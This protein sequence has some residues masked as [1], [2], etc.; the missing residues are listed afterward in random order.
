[1][2]G[3][4]N[5]VNPNSELLNDFINKISRSKKGKKR[6]MI[7]FE[8]VARTENGDYLVDSEEKQN[9]RF[10]LSDFSSVSLDSGIGY[11]A[12]KALRQ[13]LG[14]EVIPTS[15]E[16]V[17][18]LSLPQEVETIGS[19]VV[20]ARESIALQIAHRQQERDGTWDTDPV[21]INDSLLVESDNNPKDADAY[22]SVEF[23]VNPIITSTNESDAGIAGDNNNDNTSAFKMVELTNT[24]KETFDDGG[25]AVI[26]TGPDPSF[27]LQ[28]LKSNIQVDSNKVLSTETD[29]TSPE[30]FCSPC[31]PVDGKLYARPLRGWGADEMG[32]DFQWED[33]RVCCFCHD[34][35]EDNIVGRFMAFNDG[36]YGHLNCI[37]WSTDVVERNGVLTNSFIARE[38]VGKSLCYLCRQNGAT[39]GCINKKKCKRN[40]HLRCALA[41]KVL[42]FEARRTSDAISSCHDIFTLSFCPEHVSESISETDLKLLWTPTRDIRRCI[43][44]SD[45]DAEISTKASDILSQKRSDKAIRMGSITILSI[46]NP[47]IDLTDFHTPYHIYP[48]R[49]RSARIF[50]SMKNPLQRTVYFF[51]IFKF[52]DFEGMDEKRVSYIKESIEVNNLKIPSPHQSSP[53]NDPSITNV[54]TDGGPKDVPVFRIVAVDSPEEP[55]FTLS[56]ELAYTI[57]ADKVQQ[58]NSELRSHQKHCL[59]KSMKSYGLNGHQFFGIGLP[60]VRRAIEFIPESVSTMIGLD[61]VMH[62]Q[63]KP[64]YRIPTIQDAVLIHQMKEK[65]KEKGSFSV[66]GCAR[67]DGLDVILQGRNG[68]ER[69]V[70]TRILSKAVDQSDHNNNNDD[71]EA[72]VDFD[73]EEVNMRDNERNKI[74]YNEMSEAYLR[75]PNAKL[76]VK[77]S[78]I[79]GWGLFAKIN[80]EKNDIIVEYIGEKIRQVIADRR[81]VMYEVEGVGSCY[82]FR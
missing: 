19:A 39:I 81:E 40:F 37:R 79:H 47:R 71:A 11:Y 25:D 74:R 53:I 21:E 32:P 78:R 23:D 52:S 48:H 60:F 58:L 14:G 57:I 41:S 51:E 50:W 43:A 80:F 28:H 12:S 75:N 3:T 66:N 61:K 70:L 38:R 44:V 10:R 76:E 20:A 45:V 6:K 82:L 7:G 9:K 2:D 13:F 77:R 65:S 26:N 8:G 59:R 56:I 67:A 29:K 34:N 54:P 68:S 22:K 1:M 49:F 64:T 35:K 4:H 73:E 42:L 72:E 17:G 55:I 31:S 30:I 24:S 15:E 18:S 62:L 63:Y 27:S 33:P 5:T 46:G 16:P 69:K 36:V